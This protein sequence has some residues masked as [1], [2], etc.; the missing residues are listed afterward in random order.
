MLPDLPE[1][2]EP[3]VQSWSVYIVACANHS[4]YTGI[5][6]D[7]GKRVQAHNLGSGAKYTRSHLPV[8]LV[9]SEPCTSHRQA[10]QRE[11][12][13]KQLSHLAKQ[14]LIDNSE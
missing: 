8:R 4:F 10:L 3:P 5:A 6:V 12:A 7:V 13:I 9:Y 11:R 2:T 1:N 14:Q